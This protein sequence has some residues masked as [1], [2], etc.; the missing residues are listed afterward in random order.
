MDVDPDI[1]LTYSRK[2]VILT[3]LMTL[4]GV[5]VPVAIPVIA[6]IAVYLLMSALRKRSRIVTCYE[7][8][9]RTNHG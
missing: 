7:L 5:I 3:K 9:L 2:L 4:H 1:E 6:T 8:L